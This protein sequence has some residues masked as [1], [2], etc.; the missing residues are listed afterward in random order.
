MLDLGSS[1]N[2]LFISTYTSGPVSPPAFFGS[3]GQTKFEM[4]NSSREGHRKTMNTRG[5]KSQERHG[6]E[7]E[8]LS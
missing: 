8:T 2:D 6:Y 4:M 3:G 7:R 1:T 5:Q